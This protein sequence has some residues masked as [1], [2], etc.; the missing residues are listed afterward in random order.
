MILDEHITIVGYNRR[1]IN[2]QTFSKKEK[3]LLHKKQNSCKI[4]FGKS[5]NTLVLSDCNRKIEQ[6]F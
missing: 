5:D 6:K 3:Q 4:I 1:H 2:V